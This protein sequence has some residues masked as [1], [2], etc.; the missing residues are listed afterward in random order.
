MLPKR[1]FGIDISYA[2]ATFAP[3]ERNDLDFVILKASQANFPDP[4]F[5]SY[6]PPALRIPIRGAYHYFIT[7]RV[8]T[9]EMKPIGAKKNKQGGQTTAETVEIAGFTWHE[10]AE[11]FLQQVKDNQPAD[12]DA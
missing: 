12:K 3:P 10:Q 4:K 6:Y 2:Q 5:G 1:A 9:T 8:T 11:V 7:S